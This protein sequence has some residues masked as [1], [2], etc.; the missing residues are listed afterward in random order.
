MFEKS[1]AWCKLPCG[2]EKDRDEA[3]FLNCY[4]AS[5][6]GTQNAAKTVFF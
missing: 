3:G 6:R 2:E 5:S 4:P 1:S